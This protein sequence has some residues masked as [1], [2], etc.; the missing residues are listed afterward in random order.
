MTIMR[1]L[2]AAVL[3]IPLLLLSCRPVCA[4]L[5][6]RGFAAVAGTV[7]DAAGAPVQGATILV[8]QNVDERCIFPDT[9]HR[10][11]FTVD[12]TADAG[13][14]FSVGL[15]AFFDSRQCI[16]VRAFRGEPHVTDSATA[17]DFVLTFREKGERV[18]TQVVAFVLP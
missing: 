3:A 6:P 17:A 13:G 4:C 2:P 12:T 9:G 18:D 8:R 11:G 1:V 16:R 14:R 5:P 7:H 10:P 15:E